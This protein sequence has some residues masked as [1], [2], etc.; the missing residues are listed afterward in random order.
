VVAFHP[1]EPLW[2]VAEIDLGN[3]EAP[4]NLELTLGRQEFES[5]ITRF[6]GDLSSWQRG[7]IPEDQKAELA[8]KSLLGVAPPELDGAHWLNVENSPL[9]LADLRGKYVLLQFWTTWCG[10]C[11]AD[12]PS[13]RL[14]DQLY[15]DKG[16]V[17]IGIHDN[18]MP[19][20]AVEADVSKEKLSY[21]IVVDHPDGRILA[22]YRKHG[23]SGFPS[24]VLIGPD[25][26]VLKDDETVACP[27]LRSFK[28]EIVRELL[29]TRVGTS[30]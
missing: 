5:L 16:L 8:A 29:M 3:V 11:H 7:I 22:A 6:S 14:L 30:P 17:V 25:G 13:L 26:T 23:I 9:S 1:A 20:E 10:P 2:A 4:R 12:M 28:I 27:T 15:R 24:Y 19:L 21:P 18:S